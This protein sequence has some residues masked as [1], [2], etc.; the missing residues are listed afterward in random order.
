MYFQVN[1]KLLAQHIHENTGKTVLL[2]D[3]HS[4]AASVD[5][6]DRPEAIVKMLQEDG[7]NRIVY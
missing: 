5:V 7:E 3:I 1:K 2:K 4:L 6:D